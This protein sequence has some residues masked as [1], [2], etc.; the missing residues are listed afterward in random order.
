M[1]SPGDPALAADSR[2]RRRASATTARRSTARSC[3][4]RWRRGLR[5]GAMSRAARSVGLYF[6]PADS[7]IRRLLEDVRDWHAGDN[8]SDWQRDAA[9]RSPSATATTSSAA[10]ATSFPTTRSSSWRCSRRRSFQAIAAYRQHL[11]LGHRLQ[12]GNV[13]CLLGIRNGL[14]GLDAGPDWRG[15]VADRHLHL[16]GRRR[17]RGH[18]RGDRD[19]G[20]GR[21]RHAARRRA[22]ARGTRRTARA[23]TSRS[24]AA[25]RA[26]PARTMR[27][28]GSSPL[29]VGASPVASALGF[30]RPRA[31]PRGT[32]L[33][34]D[35]LRQGRPRPCRPTRSS[36]AR[37][38]TPARPST[39]AG[40]RRARRHGERA[41]YASVFDAEDVARRIPTVSA[42][43]RDRSV[44]S[45]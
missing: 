37:R 34:A 44:T 1:V 36:P 40:G 30:R 33:D 41:A 39:A 13:G 14:A 9:R 12:R 8:G 27:R 24:P 21:R 5:R 26:S 29:T 42:H 43:R 35:L 16:L 19:A 25:C 11:R 31:G 45:G 18:R 7:L 22:A 10:T 15:P 2:G 20:A 38:S 6:V 3:S 4:P 17:A 28:P 23:S 32:R